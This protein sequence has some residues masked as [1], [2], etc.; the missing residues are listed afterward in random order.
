MQKKTTFRRPFLIELLYHTMKKVKFILFTLG[1][2][3][4]GANQAFAATE[5]PFSSYLGGIRGGAD[6]SSA[7]PVDIVAPKI[8]FVYGGFYPDTSTVLQNFSGTNTWGNLCGYPDCVTFFNT[9]VSP[10]NQWAL[11]SD[12]VYGD[13]YFSA[14]WNGSTWEPGV[15][16]NTTHFNSISI[17]TTTQTVRFRGYINSTD[18]ASSTGLGG[19]GTGLNIS[20]NL[21]TP[22]YSNWDHDELVATTSGA[23]D[24]S[25]PYQNFSTSTLDIYTFTG[26]IYARDFSCNPFNEATC[27][28]IVYDTIST[29]TNANGL[30]VTH[31][32]TPA[33]ID[34]AVAENC[35]PLSSFY[36]TARCISYLVFPNP[37]QVDEN[38]ATLRD[39]FLN[40]VP[41]GYVTRFILIFT[42]TATTT[43]PSIDY[44]FSTTSPLYVGDGRI[45]FEPFDYVSGA[46]TLLTEAR[47]DQVIP[48]T[49]WQIMERIVTIIVYLMLIFMIVHD[50]TGVLKHSNRNET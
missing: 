10:S 22:V 30:G 8:G 20:F 27:A 44:T 5:L 28:N 48:K 34:Q 33:E 49:I 16:D 50:L 7:I 42:N 35:N 36:N 11:I 29:T 45:H 32:P 15:S 21:S 43:L 26:E 9:L 12:P 46:G 4:L 17:S 41:V 40:R 37:T 3:L 31:L 14:H 13:F 1:L 19:P 18:L 2:F 24:L 23:F 25:F 47:S 6:I 38:I 39:S